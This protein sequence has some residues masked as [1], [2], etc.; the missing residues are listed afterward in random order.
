MNGFPKRV[1]IEGL[2]FLP[3]IYSSSSMSKTSPD[4]FYSNENCSHWENIKIEIIQKRNK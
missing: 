3:G 2:N 1:R 4:E